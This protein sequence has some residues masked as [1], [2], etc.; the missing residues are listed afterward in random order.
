MQLEGFCFVHRLI[1]VFVKRNGQEYWQGGKEEDDKDDDGQPAQFLWTHAHTMCG[2]GMPP[3]LPLLI[4]Q[5]TTIARVADITS[6]DSPVSTPTAGYKPGA[7]AGAAASIDHDHH[8][9]DGDLADGVVIMTVDDMRECHQPLANIHAVVINLARKP[10][11]REHMMRIASELGLHIQVF[12]ALDGASMSKEDLIRYGQQVLNIQAPL[13]FRDDGG[14]GDPIKIVAALY[15]H[16]TVLHEFLENTNHSSI[17]VFEDDVSPTDR[18]AVNTIKRLKQDVFDLDPSSFHFV[19]LE[20]KFVRD[21]RLLERPIEETYSTSLR[22][23]VKDGKNPTVYGSAA[24]LYSREGARRYLDMVRRNPTGSCDH[25]LPRLLDDNDTL[26]WMAEPIVFQQELT[27]LPSDIRNHCYYKAEKEYER[28]SNGHTNDVLGTLWQALRTGF[29][30]LYEEH[31]E[32]IKWEQKLVSTMAKVVAMILQ[33]SRALDCPLDEM[34]PVLSLQHL[35][36]HHRVAFASQLRYLLLTS[37]HEDTYTECIATTFEIVHSSLPEEILQGFPEP[38]NIDSSS[39]SS[40]VDIA[41]EAISKAH[42][43]IE[44]VWSSKKNKLATFLFVVENVEEVLCGFAADGFSNERRHRGCGCMANSLGGAAFSYLYDAP[45]DRSAGQTIPAGVMQWGQCQADGAYWCD[46]LPPLYWQAAVDGTCRVTSLENNQTV[47]P[48]CGSSSCAFRPHQGLEMLRRHVELVRA[49]ERGLVEHIDLGND[50][51]NGWA[52]KPVSVY[53]WT[54]IVVP[55][56][57]FLSHVTA[58]LVPWDE[59]DQGLLSTARRRRAIVAAQGVSGLLAEHLG[60]HIPVLSLNLS[61]LSHPVGTIKS[62]YS[63]GRLANERPSA[64]ASGDTKSEDQLAHAQQLSDEERFERAFQAAQ[65]RWMT[66]L[67]RDDHKDQKNRRLKNP[68]VTHAKQDQ[69]SFPPLDHFIDGVLSSFPLHDHFI[70]GVLTV[71]SFPLHDHFIDGVLSSVTHAKQD[72]TSFPPLDHFIDGVLSSFPLHD[73]FIDGVLLPLPPSIT[74]APNM[75]KHEKDQHFPS[76]LELPLHVDSTDADPAHYFVLQHAVVVLFL[77]KEMERKQHM[78]RMVQSLGIKDDTKFFAGPDGRLLGEE[79]I[80]AFA[81]GA[82]PEAGQLTFPGHGGISACE[83]ANTLAMMKILSDFLETNQTSLLLLEDDVQPNQDDNSNA[84]QVLQAARKEIAAGRFDIIWMEHFLTPLQIE[85]I[86]TGRLKTLNVTDPPVFVQLRNKFPSVTH[87]ASQE[88][89]IMLHQ[90]EEYH[91]RTGMLS[92]PDLQGAL[93]LLVPAFREQPSADILS[94]LVQTLIAFQS[95]AWDHFWPSIPLR[96]MPVLATS[97]IRQKRYSHALTALSRLSAPVAIEYSNFVRVYEQQKVHQGSPCIR[98][99]AMQTHPSRRRPFESDGR[100]TA[101]TSGWDVTLVS[102]GTADK[103]TAVRQTCG[104]WRGQISFALFAQ[105]EEDA[106][107]A[108][109]LCG[110]SRP[111]I[112]Y[113]LPAQSSHRSISQDNDILADPYSALV[114]PTFEQ[115]DDEIQSAVAAVPE[116]GQNNSLNK[117]LQSPPD[118][119]SLHNCVQAQKC[120]VFKERQAAGRGHAETNSYVWLKAHVQ[121][122]KI[123]AKHFD[124]GSGEHCA[125][126]QAAPITKQTSFLEGK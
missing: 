90:A 38:I 51:R 100:N 81:R 43:R 87:G 44:P 106:S 37:F 26:A 17:L 18:N 91:S 15:S 14:Y 104:R 61:S 16:M 5:A 101:A 80:R 66:D 31:T 103:L 52:P 122:H 46:E 82:L 86:G 55:Y 6:P 60:R 11:R 32:Y 54:E 77:E 57:H 126:D 21:V 48:Q 4:Q 72:Q 125:Q 94:L 79:G 12:D 62:D 23:M 88:A 105:T 25:F 76:K 95:T 28:A 109:P 41:E 29:A 97:L 58:M 67:D 19:W 22:R 108:E 124:Q 110:S 123:G 7:A 64:V 70:D 47:R 56:E 118:M 115:L 75:D 53:D 33:E 1:Y 120:Q 36:D 74:G 27:A 83:C 45:V 119:K 59:T 107:L 102:Q 93:N 35:S 73:H 20:Q 30:C 13:E 96:W 121:R 65:D 42:G 8:L 10:E 84:F 3:H 24:M 116:R 49:R 89:F 50:Y 2:I 113:K 9:L 39:R 69:T 92:V 63:H 99:K 78:E 114:V 117:S 34:L 71:S 68:S 111:S 40:R 85:T 112:P 98:V